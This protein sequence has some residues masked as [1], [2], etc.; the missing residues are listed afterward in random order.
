MTIL[1]AKRNTSSGN[2]EPAENSQGN[3]QIQL[4]N[5]PTSRLSL[6]LSQSQLSAAH[7][8]LLNQVCIM[9]K[10]GTVD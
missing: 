2:E 10:Y 7:S 1:P 4:V 3:Q 9:S 6:N 5:I 8:L